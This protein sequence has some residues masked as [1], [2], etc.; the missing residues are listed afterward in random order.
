MNMT[1]EALQDGAADIAA[2][3]WGCVKNNEHGLQIKSFWDGDELICDWEPKKYHLGFPGILTGGIIATIIDC[4]CIAMANA[5]FA[6]ETGYEFDMTKLSGV[7]VTG[8]LTV[9][10]IRPTPLKAVHLRAKVIEMG[11]KKI[12]VSC[13]LSSGE[14]LCATGEIT[15][16]R[17]V[18]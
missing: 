11:E 10:F 17:V 1:S 7:F 14:A 8:T 3:C 9:K 4:H 16:I 2:S 6:R 5:F 18:G 12:K 13:D 15:A